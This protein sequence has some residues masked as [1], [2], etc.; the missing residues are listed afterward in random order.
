MA[1]K[2]TKT[3]A[4]KLTKRALDAI[5]KLMTDRLMQPDSVVPITMDSFKKSRQPLKTAFNKL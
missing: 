4:K 2:L 1:K 3:Q 5:G